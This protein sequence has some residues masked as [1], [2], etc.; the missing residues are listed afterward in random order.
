M[1]WKH[2]PVW[3]S[4]ILSPYNSFCRG[5]H[6]N[7]DAQG[8][9]SFS[10]DGVGVGITYQAGPSQQLLPSSPPVSSAHLSVFAWKLCLPIRVFI[11]NTVV[12]LKLC[13]TYS[14]GT[15]TL[16][17]RKQQF[18]RVSVCVWGEGVGRYHKNIF[19][20]SYQRRH[21]GALSWKPVLT[22]GAALR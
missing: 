21:I 16:Y 20:A 13:I 12:T 8:N 6:N 18:K 7:H 3:N 9:S 1:H 19:K 15:A 5:L 2:N 10:L 17:K 22:S 14:L 4:W 11:S